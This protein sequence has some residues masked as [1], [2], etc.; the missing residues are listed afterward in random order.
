MLRDNVTVTC[1][2]CWES[3]V[4]QVDLSAGDQ[5]YVEDCA[6][7]C[8]PILVNCRIED[9]ELVDISVERES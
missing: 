3:I 7:C 2:H 9:G 4:I 1:P 5:S 6:V 8:A